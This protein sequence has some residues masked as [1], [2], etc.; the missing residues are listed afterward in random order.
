MCQVWKSTPAPLRAGVKASYHL[1]TETSD[2]V[3]FAFFVYDIKF[4]S[5]KT[6]G[7]RIGI[8]VSFGQR[9][10]VYGYLFLSRGYNRWCGFD[11]MRVVLDRWSQEAASTV[12][13]AYMNSYYAVVIRRR[14][15]RGEMILIH[16]DSKVLLN[17]Q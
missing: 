1:G 5:P 17:H 13:L 3:V 9:S 11:S 2:M 12:P 8:L 14:S 7:S 4:H 6:L 16:S 10:P 15:P